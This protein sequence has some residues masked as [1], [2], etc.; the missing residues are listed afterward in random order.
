MKFGKTVAATLCLLTVA[1]AL[2]QGSHAVRG[3][4][5]RD[6]TY[7]APHQQ[8]NPNSTRLDNWSTRGNVNPY[9]GQIGTRDPN[10]PSASPYRSRSTTDSSNSPDDGD[11]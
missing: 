8:T 2:A 11:Q 7:V 10:A 4:T 3:Y 1:P 9:T 5:R 6:G